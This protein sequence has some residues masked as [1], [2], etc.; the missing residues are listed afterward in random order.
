MI[1]KSAFLRAVE[2]IPKDGGSFVITR[3]MLPSVFLSAETLS[4]GSG[5]RPLA[6][7]DGFSGRLSCLGSKSV[8]AKSAIAIRL[9]NDNAYDLH[10]DQG[11][12]PIRIG[13]HVMTL[14]GKMLVFDGGYRVPLTG[15]IK[16]NSSQDIEVDLKSIDYEAVGSLP[17]KLEFALLQEGNAWFGNASCRIELK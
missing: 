15:I 16:S 13:V 4:K 17:V 9:Y 12:Y 8:G 1:D 10:L 6:A 7:S 3:D 14:D 5:D 11:E 2:A